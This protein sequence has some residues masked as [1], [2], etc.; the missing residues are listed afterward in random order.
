MN[1]LIIDTE[2]ANCVE[3]PLPYDIGYQIVNTFSGE[4][5]VAR[6]FVV[7]EIFLDK[8]LMK[9]AYFAEKIPQYWKEIKSK[10]RTLKRFINIRKILWRDMKQYQVNKVGAYNMGFDKRATNNDTRFIT[11][12]FLRWFF[13]YNTTFFASGTWLA[14]P[15]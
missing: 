13:P 8:E 12:S 11:A 15:F 5:L 2:T 4:V 1:I 14:L 10:K 7:A 9:E 3:Q 6:S